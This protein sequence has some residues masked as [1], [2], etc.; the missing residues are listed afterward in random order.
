[1][2][3]QHIIYIAVLA[4]SLAFL[5]IGNRVATGGESTRVRQSQEEWLPAVVSEIT[6]IIHTS[7]QYWS[8]VTITFCT[9]YTWRKARRYS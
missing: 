6:D 9:Y 2:K 4:F 8:A 3:T 7:D 5:F 1:M